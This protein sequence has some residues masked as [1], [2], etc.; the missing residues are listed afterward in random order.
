MDSRKSRGI[1]NS[2]PGNIDLSADVW[3]GELRDPA[4]SRLTEFQ[5][6]E[7]VNGRFAVA[8]P[9]IRM[10]AKTRFAGRLRQLERAF[11]EEL[12]RVK[13]SR[14]VTTSRAIGVVNKSVAA[15]YRVRKLARRAFQ[16]RS[17]P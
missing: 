5:R 9:G 16:S 17:I 11:A 3:Q 4:D 12:L 6:N 14:R 15:S 2:N 13:A 1:L 8:W 10:L 7:L